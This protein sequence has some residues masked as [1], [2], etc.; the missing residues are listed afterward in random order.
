MQEP[1]DG[2]WLSGQVDGRRIAQRCGFDELDGIGGFDEL[3][4]FDGLDE[5][6]GLDEHGKDF[7]REA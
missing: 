1:V 6:D 2:S 5:I 4:G 7:E 3:D